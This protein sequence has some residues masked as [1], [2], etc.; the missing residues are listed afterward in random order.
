[1]KRNA[2]FIMD[3]QK[4]AN[5]VPEFSNEYSLLEFIETKL[6]VKSRTFG[7]DY[8]GNGEDTT[9]AV[10]WADSS[11]HGRGTTFWGYKIKNDG[12]RGFFV[13]AKE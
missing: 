5:A 13:K 6:L 2:T 4:I 3:Y 10:P 7:L 1:M 9:G 8:E 12:R 11:N